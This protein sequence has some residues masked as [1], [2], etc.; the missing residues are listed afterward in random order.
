MRDK[1][2]YLDRYAA[3]N[4][5]IRIASRGTPHQWPEKQVEILPNYD[6]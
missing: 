5:I 2:V 4:V 3:A 6:P 1:L